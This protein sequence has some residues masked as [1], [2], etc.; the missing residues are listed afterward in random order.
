[1]IPLLP[2][3]TKRVVE[4]PIVEGWIPADWFVLIFE[5]LM[6]SHLNYPFWNPKLRKFCQSKHQRIAQKEEVG[7]YSSMFKLMHICILLSTSPKNKKF[8][9]CLR[10]KAVFSQITYVLNTLE[11]KGVDIGITGFPRCEI[12][13]RI[14]LTMNRSI[15]VK[16]YQ[17]LAKKMENRHFC[18]KKTKKF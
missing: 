3:K 15:T 17:V 9:P 16:F 10:L 18:G 4:R 7:Y 2:N 11:N 13:Y 1:M 5:F 6:I 14:L 8:K 12:C